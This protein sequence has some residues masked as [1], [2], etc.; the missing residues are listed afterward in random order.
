MIAD[1]VPVMRL[2]NG[3][4]RAKPAGTA[5]ARCATTRLPNM[6]DVARALA[7]VIAAIWVAL[8]RAER[9]PVLA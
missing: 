3:K 5:A 2:R 4:A 7:A 8:T 9:D 6:I 1:T